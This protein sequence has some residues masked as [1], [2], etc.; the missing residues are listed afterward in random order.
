MRGALAMAE[1][2]RAHGLA[3]LLV[4]RSRAR[5]AALVEGSRSGGGLAAEAVDVL[6]GRASPRRCPRRP[7]SPTSRPRLEPPD[8]SDVRGHN[9]LMPAIEVAAAGGHNLFL[10]G[11]PGTGKTML[12]RRLPSILPP[13]TRAEAIEVTRL[14]SIAGLHRA[15]GWSRRGRSARR[16]TRSRRPG[17]SAAARC[18]RRARRRSPTTACCSS[19]SCPSSRAGAR[20]AAPAARGRARHDRPRA[21]G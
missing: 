16:T 1:G 13:L 4:P 20:G 11:P 8:L 18:R 7:P 17:W 14:H 10:H 6:A 2:T 15:A 9:A 5:E 19:T 12:A 3:R 21:S